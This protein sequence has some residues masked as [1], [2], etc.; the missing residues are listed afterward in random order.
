MKSLILALTILFAPL[1]LADQQG[2]AT[3]YVIVI[4]PGVNWPIDGK[5]D[6]NNPEIQKHGAYWGSQ[7]ALIEKGGP[8]IGRG[9]GMM[10][11]KLGTSLEAAQKAASA[12]P[13]VQSQFLNAEVRQ[14]LLFLNNSSQ[15]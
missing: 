3:Q 1:V 15:K 6:S 10:L 4:T 2:P 14:W 5:L 7:S 8:F 9:S 12:D 13:A 11:V